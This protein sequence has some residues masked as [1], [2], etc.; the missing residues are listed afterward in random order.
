MIE[1]YQLIT[2]DLDDTLWDCFPVIERA[3]TTLFNWL[4]QYYPKITDGQTLATMRDA[5]L[6][7]V[8]E[9]PDYQ[10]N[11]SQLR[12]DSLKQLAKQHGYKPTLADKAFEVFIVARNNIYLF[13]DALNFLQRLKASHIKVAAITNGNADVKRIG[14]EHYFDVSV[15]A[16]EVDKGKPYSDMFDY[17][18]KS[19]AIK[20]QDCL[21]IGDDAYSD[22]LGALNAGIDFLWMNRKQ[23]TWPKALATPKYELSNF[24]TL[25]S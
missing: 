25:Y 11:L 21:H 12:I 7:M 18:L 6:Q 4:S 8:K 20:K 22:G 15:K 2:L 23:Q 14:I 17:V 24:T 16:E 13:D 10:F 1:N 3:E 9:M 19:L 5:R